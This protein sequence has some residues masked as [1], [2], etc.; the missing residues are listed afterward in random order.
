VMPNGDRGW[1]TDAVSIP[2]WQFETFMTRDLIGFV[3]SAFHT[4]PDRAGRAIGHKMYSQ[5]R[6]LHVPAEGPNYC[7]NCVSGL[8]FAEHSYRCD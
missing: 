5:D 7:A 3:D 4:I 8:K 2:D 1:Y 6:A